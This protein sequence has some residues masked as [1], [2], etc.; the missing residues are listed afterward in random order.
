MAHPL[1]RTPRFPFFL[2][3][4]LLYLSSPL[5]Y[6][7]S[8]L[9]PHPSHLFL[10]LSLSSVPI[11]FSSSPLSCLLFIMSFSF[12]FPSSLLF[13]KSTAFSSSAPLSLPAHHFL[14]QRIFFFFLRELPVL[15][16]LRELFVP[17]VLR[18]LLVPYVLREL[19]VLYVIED[20]IDCNLP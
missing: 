6:L 16:L 19:L 4:S 13:L 1:C 5:Q 8:F 11:F 7:S 12:V 10:L 20:T 17:H 18:E 2:P 3:P 15:C 14:S 9:S